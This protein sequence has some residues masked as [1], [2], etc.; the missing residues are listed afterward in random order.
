MT[1]PTSPAPAASATAARAPHSPPVA[2]IDIGSNSIK[3]LV[4][5]RAAAPLAHTAPEAAAPLPNQHEHAHAKSR[6]AAGSPATA[7]APSAQ[8]EALFSRSINV[9]LS[10]GAD[11]RDGR[12]T[13]AP[14][15]MGAALRATQ[16]LL[17]DAAPYSPRKIALI[18]TSALRDAANA[19]EFTALVRAHTGHHIRILSG[20]EEAALIGRGLLCDPAL[21]AHSHAYAFDLGG[22]S[23][24]C[25]K[26]RDGQLSTA[27]SLPLGSVRLMARCVAD[28]TAPLAPTARAKIRAQVTQSF[29]ASGFALDLPENAPLIGTGGLWFNVRAMLAAQHR[30]SVPQFPE[31]LETPKATRKA[32][33]QTKGVDRAPPLPAA[34][35]NPAAPDAAA[36]HAELA[37]PWITRAQISQILEQAA[38]L[39]LAGRLALP[40]IAAARAD[41]LPVALSTMLAL[42]DLGQWPGLHHSAYNLRYGLAASLL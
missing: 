15:T 7:A 12:P 21:Q 27:L 28:P 16:E 39:P 13:L 8:I 38:A 25:L 22:G 18:G 37:P 36:P 33:T 5:R 40:G 26:L 20:S 9:R 3:T 4:A 29:A 10:A 14:E 6:A 30:A 42:L 35:A 23:L 34:R 32:C 41:I 24:E 19:A 31:P 1:A 11:W 17:C 2:V